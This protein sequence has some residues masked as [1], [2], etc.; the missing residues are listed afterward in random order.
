M[1]IPKFSNAEISSLSAQAKA[2]FYYNT[3][4]NQ[5]YFYNGSDYELL[6]Q[7]VIGLSLN[8]TTK[9]LTLS[10]QDGSSQAV[11]LTPIAGLNGATGPTGAT[12]PSGPLDIPV[13]RF[14]KTD[15]QDLNAV[16]ANS[17]PGIE[18]IWDQESISSSLF[19][20]ISGNTRIRANESGIYEVSCAIPIESFGTSGNA[21]YNGFL[22]LAVNG[23]RQNYKTAS[24]Y[25][26]NSG[27]NDES[28]LLFPSIAIQLNANDNISFFVRRESSNSSPLRQSGNGAW[29][30]IKKIS[31]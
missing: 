3:D 11:D 30:S 25:I 19:T 18:V 5:V 12:G 26:R 21:R 22:Y 8:S 29:L 23:N 10:F 4:D 14:G 1:G 9:I 24:S 28:S 6:S 31:D 27:G 2:V 15:A 20:R 17:D 16:A 13:A 7:N